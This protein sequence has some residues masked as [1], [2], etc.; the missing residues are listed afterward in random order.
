ML[1]RAVAVQIC[2]AVVN[3]CLV[4]FWPNEP[5]YLIAAV[6]WSA[7]PVLSVLSWIHGRMSAE[8]E[9]AEAYR[10]HGII[11]ELR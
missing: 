1:R 7:V 4:A 3:W 10:A 2:I 9:R 6:A 8:R 5:V 11:E